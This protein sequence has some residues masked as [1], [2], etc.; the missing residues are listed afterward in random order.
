MRS[1]KVTKAFLALV[2]AG[3]WN[4]VESVGVRYQ[5]FAKPVDWNDIYQLAEEQSVQGL[6]LQG[7]DSFKIQNPR[8]KIPQELLLQWIGEVQQIE[9]RN[10]AMNKF[11]ARL[12]QKLRNQ[13]IY[14]ILVKGQG[15]ARCYEKPLWRAAGDIDLFLNGDDYNKAI[16]F[17]T[18]LANEIADITDET[19]HYALNFRSW[20]VELH[21]TL[22]SQL[23][24]KI[25]NTIDRIQENTFKYGEVRTW[26]NEGIEVFLPSP[27]NDVL[28]VFIHIL[29]H[30]F[31]GG[32]GLRQLCDLSRLLWTY[33]YNID[34][35]LLNKRLTM[36]GVMT[37]WKAFGCVIVDVL[38][39]PQETFPFYDRLYLHK[40]DRIISYILE[41]GNFGHNKDISYQKMHPS[42][43]RKIITFG[44][45]AK[46][47]IKLS[48]IF[49]IDAPWFLFNYFV[50][51]SKT[52]LDGA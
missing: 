43:V 23:S 40:S 36:M 52:V 27:N 7:I 9:Q 30:F 6:V 14:S 19:K 1:E 48:L 8:F 3:L 41:V 37:E 18:P 47:S 15:I 2:R 21:G 13:G 10:V 35:D 29:Q 39:L 42:I 11:I 33:R 16:D 49:P 45:Q 28:F 51:G 5:G 22:H 26:C 24:E 31:F 20:E 32:I 46:D 17:L 38:G 50:R 4:D 25:D 34:H 12:S 44:R